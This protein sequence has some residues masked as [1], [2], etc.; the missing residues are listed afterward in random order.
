MT[1]IVPLAN[2][3]DANDQARLAHLR[4]GAVSIGNFDGVHRGHAALLKQLRSTADRV[5]GPAVAIALAPH[6]AAILRPDKAPPKLTSLERRAERMADLGVDALVICDTRGGLL[7]LSAQQFYDALIRQT[8]DA[9]AVIEGPNFFFGRGREGDIAALGQM[10]Q[11]DQTELQIALPTTM[12]G[13]M[14]SSTRIRNCLAQ[15]ELATAN[16]LLGTDY[17]INGQVVSGSRRGRTIGFP[18]ANL[19]SIETVIPAVGV[20][21][22][23]V[24]IGNQRHLAA[25]HIGP[26]PTFNEDGDVKVEVHVIDYDGDLYGQTLTVDF[27]THVRG[28]TKFDSPKQLAE[29]LGRDIQTIRD[30]L[31]QR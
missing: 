14:I 1:N 11:A 27:A 3:T 25:I 12:A 5:G 24:R 26:N 18:T 20:Y 19:E 6:P 22:G 13:E 7:K 17:R 29:Q 16:Q 30:Q 9:K 23:R 2:V 10:C 4:G 21:G 8:L 28:I 15:G 31:A